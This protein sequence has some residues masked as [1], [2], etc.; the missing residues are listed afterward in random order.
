MDKIELKPC[1]FCGSNRLGTEYKSTLEKRIGLNGRI[2]KHTYSVRCY[3][4][5]ARGGVISGKIAVNLPLPY[6]QATTDDELKN[7]AIHAWNRRTDN[8]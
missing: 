5:H 4:C 1:P 8:G 3:S 6:E 2:E 7:L